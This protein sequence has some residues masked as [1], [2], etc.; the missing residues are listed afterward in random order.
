[1]TDGAR[2]RPP[3]WAWALALVPLA[4]LAVA[5][6]LVLREPPPPVATRVPAPPA[7]AAV[8]PSAAVRAGGRPNDV[9]HAGG[10]L[11][12]LRSTRGRIAYTKDAE[13]RAG[14][15]VG[16]RPAA[17]AGGFGRVWIA[18]ARPPSLRAVGLATL[19]LDGLPVALGVP[20]EAVDVAAGGDRVW[21]GVRGRPGHVVEVDPQSRRVVRRI[22]V[23]AGVQNLDAGF[24]AVWVTTRTQD[25][26]VRIDAADGTQ[27]PVPVGRAPRV[28]AAGAGAVW[29]AESGDGSVARV[30]PRTLAVRRI[31]V[32]GRP[33]GVAV[34][35]DAVLVTDPA[36]DRVVRLDPGTGD[37]AGPAAATGRRPMALDVRGEF[38]YVASPPDRTVY[39]LRIPAR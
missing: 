7:D 33:Y 14:P 17:L 20:G 24:G 4:G 16:A 1:M 27:R 22:P 29:V 21:V 38:A 34:G 18:D 35:R 36:R 11:W 25:T 6:V 9:L 13:L 26:L 31:P 28:V 2:R 37:P 3:G 23:L 8:R 12:V 39:R 19:R 5:A 10:R 30:D 15:V 32:G